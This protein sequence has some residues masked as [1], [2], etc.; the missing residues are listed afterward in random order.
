MAG[1]WHHLAIA[2]R[3]EDVV[4]E[5]VLSQSGEG[6]AIDFGPMGRGNAKIGSKETDDAI[7]AWDFTLEGGGGAPPPHIHNSIHEVIVVLEG[8]A[9]IVI[10]D[11][12]ER[13][14]PGAL[15]YAPPGTVHGVSPS[16]SGKLRAMIIT[17][18]ASKHEEVID[19]FVK[20]AAAG[21]PDPARMAELIANV[22]VE[23]PE[24]PA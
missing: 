9:E 2:Q 18:P 1:M 16:G 24:P 8:D 13:V 10:G 20:L 5:P 6:A 7:G 4:S 3:E 21:P 12:T 17:N 11:R 14:G 15:A 23:I 19:A 22:D